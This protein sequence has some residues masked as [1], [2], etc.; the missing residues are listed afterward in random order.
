MWILLKRDFIILNMFA[1]Q[2]PNARS[3]VDGHSIDDHE[4]VIKQ[5]RDENAS[6]KER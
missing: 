1:P 5:L 6:L 3:N 2:E 4:P